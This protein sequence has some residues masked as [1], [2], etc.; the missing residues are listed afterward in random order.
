M[1]R[2]AVVFLALGV[3]VTLS[4]A[5]QALAQDVRRELAVNG[6]GNLVPPG[7]VQGM[8]VHSLGLE[9]A[10]PAETVV[11]VPADKALPP[12]GNQIFVSKDASGAA[13]LTC[14]AV[15]VSVQPAYGSLTL[16]QRTFTTAEATSY[17]AI[18]L[19]SEAFLVP[20]SSMGVGIAFT[21]AVEQDTT[22]SSP[23]VYNTVSYC[24]GLT[25]TFSPWFKFDPNSANNTSTD[26]AAYTGWAPAQPSLPT[27]VTIMA[28]GQSWGTGLSYAYSCN[29][30]LKISY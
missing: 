18:D 23:P 30:N 6:V 19:S 11:P 24:S 16:F 12:A 13:F 9:N 26:S 17:V 20:R 8:G 28:L 25:A 15:P 7:I 3:L 14:Y 27:R 2:K 1:N 5:G 21:C 10:P 22:S 29:S 4:L